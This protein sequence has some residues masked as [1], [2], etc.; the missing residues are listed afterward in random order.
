MAGS[1]GCELIAKDRESLERFL[2]AVI[3]GMPVA[4]YQKPEALKLGFVAGLRGDP[5]KETL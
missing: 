4:K 1:L 5:F 3:L 2:N